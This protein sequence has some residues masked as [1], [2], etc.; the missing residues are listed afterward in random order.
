MND[1]IE[2]YGRRRTAIRDRSGTFQAFVVSAR[3]SRQPTRM[4]L[5]FSYL[6]QYNPG[7]EYS[8]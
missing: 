3:L 8:F 7:H 5:A 6:N 1:M 4:T 2:S